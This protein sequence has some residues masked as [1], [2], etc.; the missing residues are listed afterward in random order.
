MLEQLM[1]ALPSQCIVLLED[2]DTAGLQRSEDS[3]DES[4]S[5]SHR[6]HRDRERRG[7]SLSGL[8]NAID[9]V[10]SQEGRV[11]IMTSNMP[12]KLDEALIRPGR[13]DI[14]VEF[15]NATQAQAQDLFE[16]MYVP[17]VEQPKPR[18]SVSRTT[19]L[20]LTAK[21][22]DRSVTLRTDE[23][24]TLSDHSSLQ[25][26]AAAFAS[27]V[28]DWDFSPAEIQGYLLKWKKNPE[29]AMAGAEEWVRVEGEKKAARRK[30]KEEREEKARE[31]KRKK[32][33]E[34][35]EKGKEDEKAEGEAEME[36]EKKD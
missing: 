18:D 29:Q 7:I 3:D 33:K 30:E 12:E 26:Y 4:K 34:Q 11:L 13:V 24:I 27:R 5:H 10:A 19:K 20:I 22:E 1:I 36:A 2:I 8:L 25:D 28:P 16:R 9:G 23:K 32:A 17:D 31:R 14:K 21:P 35:E 15:R 6:D